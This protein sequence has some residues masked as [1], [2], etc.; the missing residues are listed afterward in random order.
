MIKA[1]LIA[2]GVLIVVGL[3]VMALSSCGANWFP[4]CDDPK[5]PCPPV[6][7][8][9]PAGAPSRDAGDGGRTSSRDH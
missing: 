7:P 6:E 2:L 5:R 4:K 1:C 9:Y 3:I 8:D